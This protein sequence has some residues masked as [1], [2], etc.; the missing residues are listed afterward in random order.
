MDPRLGTRGSNDLGGAMFK[1]EHIRVLFQDTFKQLYPFKWK[2]HLFDSTKGG[3]R[4]QEREDQAKEQ[5]KTSQDQAKEQAKTSPNLQGKIKTQ[6]YT[7]CALVFA[8]F[9]SL[10]AFGFYLSSSKRGRLLRQ[11]DQDLLMF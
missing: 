1:G 9:V 2:S 4:K 11:H 3:E 5:A 8:T 6:S 10:F 7:K